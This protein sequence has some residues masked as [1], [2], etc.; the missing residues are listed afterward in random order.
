M[1][2]SSRAY[3][4][5]ASI[6]LELELQRHF[7]ADF[8]ECGDHNDGATNDGATN[9]GATNDGATNDGRNDVKERCKCTGI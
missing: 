6:T 2:T 7:S 5:C 8:K 9:D 1:L 4:I 3:T